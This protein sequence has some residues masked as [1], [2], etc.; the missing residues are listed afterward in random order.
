MSITIDVPPE[1]EAEL[2]EAARQ[3]GFSVESFVLDL[4]RQKVQP[5]RAMTGADALAFWDREDC[6]GLFTESPDSV[7]LVR[8]WRDEE[9]SRLERRLGEAISGC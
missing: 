4:A 2:R 1:L 7:G 3:K 9:D 6:L 8:R 5:T